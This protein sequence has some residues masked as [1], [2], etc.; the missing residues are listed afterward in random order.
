[1]IIKPE[2]IKVFDAKNSCVDGDVQDWLEKDE[3]YKRFLIT[4]IKYDAKSEISRAIVTYVEDPKAIKLFEM[5]GNDASTIQFDELYID[6]EEE[7]GYEDYLELFEEKF[8]QWRV[9]HIGRKIMRI[10]YSQVEDGFIGCLIM[11]VDAPNK[12]KVEKA[13]SEAHI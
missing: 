11:S 3:N 10:E 13:W 6:K 9:A 2:K 8:D 12:E 5:G 7:G 1:M 4:D